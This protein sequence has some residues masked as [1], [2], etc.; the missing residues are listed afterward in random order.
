MEDGRVSELTWEVRWG[1]GGVALSQRRVYSR[2]LGL[3]SCLVAGASVG[4]TICRRITRQCEG[5]EGVSLGATLELCACVVDE[6]VPGK[7]SAGF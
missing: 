3:C 4:S 1:G 2:C 7:F 5:V 6:K